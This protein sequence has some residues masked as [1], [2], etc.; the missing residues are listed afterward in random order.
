VQTVET[1]QTERLAAE[2]LS[3]DHLGEL[4]RMNRDPSVM[5]T[6]GGVR[7]DEET[8]RYLRDNLEHWE[9]Y[10]FGIWAFRDGKDGSFVAR[11][12]LRHTHVGGN[13][14]VELAYALRSEYWGRGLATELAGAVVAV[15]FERLGLDD[16][17]A[18]TLPTNRGSW[19]VMEKTGFEYE[20]DVVHAGLPHVLYR[21]TTSEWKIDAGRRSRIQREEK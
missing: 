21:I 5:A 3:L 4:L 20:R 9:R 15:G 13:D 10:G 12:G 6:L 7:P 1:F 8:E 2:R 18:F 16:V 14:E 11:A 17:V 19:R